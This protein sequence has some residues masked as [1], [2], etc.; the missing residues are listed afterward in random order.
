MRRTG[1]S[2]LSLSLIAMSAIQHSRAQDAASDV[3]MLPCDGKCATITQPLKRIRGDSLPD[4]ILATDGPEGDRYK[5]HYPE[6]LVE[7]E[8]TIQPDGHVADDISVLHV[9]G[10]PEFVAATKRTIRTWVYEPATVDG[11]PVA[12]SHRAMA[13]FNVAEVS[14]PRAS[15]VQAYATAG[16]LLKTGNFDQAK[17]KLG[18]M[19]KLP[20]LTFYERGL[21]MYPL[22][23]IA[24]Q[25]QEYLE[26]NRLSGLALVFGPENF[27]EAAYRGMIRARIS[28]SLAMGDLVGAAKYLGV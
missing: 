19:L 16:E 9:I 13:F 7:V 1:L 20:S 23:L 24:M 2:L 8:F 28:S 22:V 26:A 6:G 4:R 15:V 5:P 25:R 18:E 14:D 12:V 21:I 17:A 3:V 10:P 27:S 11:Q